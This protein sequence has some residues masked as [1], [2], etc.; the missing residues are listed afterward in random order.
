V[1]YAKSAA[2]RSSPVMKNIVVFC[3]G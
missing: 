3:K 2:A 1:M